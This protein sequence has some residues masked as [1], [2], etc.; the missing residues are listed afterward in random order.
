LASALKDKIL[1]FNAG[2]PLR[3]TSPT[4]RMGDDVSAATSLRSDLATQ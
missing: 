4:V 1:S 3:G 2:L